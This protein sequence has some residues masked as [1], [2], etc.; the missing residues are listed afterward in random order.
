MRVR[1]SA[2]VDL[3]LRIHPASLPP[4]HKDPTG[5]TLPMESLSGGPGPVD[6]ISDRTAGTDRRIRHHHRR[7]STNHPRHQRT[8]G[9]WT[10]GG[11]PAMLHLHCWYPWPMATLA[12]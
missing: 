2:I 3:G 8:R 1:G 7:Q 9:V 6:Q 11:A 4:D 10:C 5:L 12:L